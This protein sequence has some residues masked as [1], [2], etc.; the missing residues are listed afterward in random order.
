MSGLFKDAI[1]DHLAML[2]IIVIYI[3]I[4]RFSSKTPTYARAVFPNDQ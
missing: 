1:S 3:H 4:R 2:D